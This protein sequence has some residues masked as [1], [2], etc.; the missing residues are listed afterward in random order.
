[1]LLTQNKTKQ[2]KTKQNKTKQNKTKQ[3]HPFLAVMC[4]SALAHTF[5]PKEGKVSL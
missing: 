5:N 2:N 3:N 1:V 4:G